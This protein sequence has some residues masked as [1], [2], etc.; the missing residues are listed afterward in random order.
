MT[1]N[2]CAWQGSTLILN[3]K[4]KTRANRD[5]V[6]GVHANQLKV[7]ITATPVDGKANRHL[8]RYLAREFGIRQNDVTLLAG[9]SCPQKRI[10]IS[11]PTRH[12]S[13]FSALGK[14]IETNPT[15]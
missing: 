8:I 13:W 5:E 12:P 7:R 11:S 14:P 2:W 3:I 9:L 15:T 1:R 10:A 6:A 4:V